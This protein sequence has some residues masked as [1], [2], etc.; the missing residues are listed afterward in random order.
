MKQANHQVDPK[1][2]R[3]HRAQNQVNQ[4]NLKDLNH[5]QKNRKKT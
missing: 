5:D 4:W 1:A 2:H 3:V